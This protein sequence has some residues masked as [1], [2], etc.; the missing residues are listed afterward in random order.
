MRN[1]VTTRQ[2]VSWPLLEDLPVAE[3]FGA[4]LMRKTLDFAMKDENGFLTPPPEKSE[5]IMVDLILRRCVMGP[6]GLWEV[7]R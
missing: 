6:N 2:F 1:K 3:S 7:V 5:F 4:L